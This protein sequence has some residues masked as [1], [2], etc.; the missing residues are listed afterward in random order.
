M[1]KKRNPLG[2]NPI[3]PVDEDQ[4]VRSMVR[5]ERPREKTT[6]TSGGLLRKTIYF[7]SEEWAYIRRRGYEDERNYSEIVREAVR[8][9]MEQED[10]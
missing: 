1:S 2:S 6:V 10:V 9:L 3:G 5:G 8:R 7:D 4:T